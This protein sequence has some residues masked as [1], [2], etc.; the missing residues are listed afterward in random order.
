MS[1]RFESYVK[2]MIPRCSDYAGQIMRIYKFDE[3]DEDWT[4]EIRHYDQKWCDGVAGVR[5]Y[6]TKDDINLLCAALGVPN[7]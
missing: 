6:R 5:Q 1:A 4:L 7:H 3:L 2:E